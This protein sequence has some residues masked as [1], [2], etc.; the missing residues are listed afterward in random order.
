MS[1][2]IRM[3]ALGQVSDELLIV[4]WLK[5]E[6][7]SVKLGEPL[8]EIETDKATLEVEA[9]EAGTLLQITKRE[10][11]TVEVG[12]VI[13]VVGKPGEK[14]QSTKIEVVQA[15]APVTAAQAIIGAPGKVLAVPTARLLAREHNIDITEISGTGP[16]GLIEKRD[17]QAAID[18]KRE[19]K[20]T[21]VARQMAREHNIN[22][23][24]VSG[25]GPNGRIE[26][27]DVESLIQPVE[28]SAPVP[29]SSLTGLPLVAGARGENQAHEGDIPIAKHRQIIAQR[30]TQ[31]VTTIPQIRLT[32]TANMSQPRAMLTAM[33][34]AGLPKLSYTHLIL[35]AVAA[36]LRA[37]PRMNSLW[38]NDGPRLRPLQ[39][40]DVGLA[41]AS[42]DN[43][44]VATI[45]EPDWT[46]LTQLVRSTDEAIE[47][48][49]RG[50]LSQIDL[51][52]AAITV[53]NLGM[54]GVDDFEAIV[55]PSQTAILAVGRVA[56]QVVVIDGGIR[57]APLM[58]LSLTVDH[59]V[60]DGALAA[61]FLNRIREELEHS[62]V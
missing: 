19:V 37:Y 52:P 58:N 21:P 7:D 25:S 55:D 3:P 6:G 57:V 53:S 18:Q 39:R 43:L 62:E 38:I 56:E 15:G 48:G 16:N 24:Q 35:R 20:I 29:L 49:R 42:E 30:L 59:R 44:L 33:R 9:A 34:A 26:K 17:V 31:S 51:K 32:M 41:I 12:T 22:L 36:A 4:R 50:M 54:Y 2:E 5:N 28:P 1:R 13:A 61:Q 27:R 46:T 47:R 23:A 8:L 40:A 11:E 14:I 60:A 45:P 10:G